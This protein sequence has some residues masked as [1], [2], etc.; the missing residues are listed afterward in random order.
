[1]KMVSIQKK[2][3]FWF[4]QGNM[5]MYNIVVKF[6]FKYSQFTIVTCRE[7]YIMGKIMCKLIGRQQSFSKLYI[8]IF[9]DKMYNI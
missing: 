5:D 1:M 8:I 2:N 3:L 9:Q 4:G 7:L 6:D